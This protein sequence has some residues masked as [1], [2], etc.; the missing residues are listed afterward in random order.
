ML[1]H[2]ARESMKLLSLNPWVWLFQRVGGLLGS[3]GL[4]LSAVII[5]RAEG[6]AKVRPNVIV[7]LADDLGVGDVSCLN[8]RSAW[9]TPGIDRIAREGRRFTDAHSASGVCTPSRYTL[10]TGR[11][12]WRGRLKSGVLHGYD[13][14]LLEPGRLTLAGFLRDQGYATGMVGKWHLGLDWERT[15]TAV[16]AVDFSR[17]FAGGPLAHGFGRYFGI[18][19][20]LDMP[21]FVYLD[22]DRATTVPVDRIEA[23]PSPKMWRTGLIG[24]DFRHEE[25]HPRFRREALAWIDSR[26][27]ARAVDG[28]PFFLYLALASPHTPTVPTP[29]FIGRSGTNPYGDFV[30]QVDATVADVLEALDRHGIARDTLVVF[31]AD[32]GCSPAANLGELRR[33]GHD[34][35]AGFRGHKA[36]LFEGGHRVPFLVRWPA[37]VPA[38]STCSRVIG[39][40]DLMATL[41]EVLGR[42]LP[43]GAG[44]DSV[45]FLAQLRRGDEARL[46]RRSLVHHS[47]QGLFA[48]REGPWKLLFT[49]DS[50]GWSDPKPGSKEAARLPALQLYHLGSDPAERTNRIAAEGAVARRMTRRMGRILADGRS[51]PGPD[52]AFDAPADWPQTTPFRPR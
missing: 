5:T 50:G 19:A 43:A 24:P 51:T 31:T 38:G 28:T 36:D 42:R 49:P 15:G 52:Q 46:G 10:L 8:P 4:M 34:P 9:K 3:V 6:P 45:G 27:R 41:A 22:Q 47:S 11:Y 48:L 17:P 1:G 35:S 32:N 21:P 7:I 2:G 16:D 18:S 40:L 44:E 33:F 39:Q 14:A 26:A 37:E 13:P 23:S 29:E 25:V 20:S 30:A 12:S